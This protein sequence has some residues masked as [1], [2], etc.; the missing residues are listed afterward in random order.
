M[1]WGQFKVP[2]CLLVL[3]ALSSSSFTQKISVSNNFFTKILSLNSMN[4]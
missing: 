3:L 4:F 1:N 2:F